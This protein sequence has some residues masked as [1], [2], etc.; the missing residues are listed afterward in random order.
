MKLTAKLLCLCLALCVALSF[1]ACNK[2]N[3]TLQP[4][5]ELPNDSDSALIYFLSGAKYGEKVYSLDQLDIYSQDSCY[6][7]FDANGM[8]ELVINDFCY[9]EFTYE[10]GIIT[11]TL[12]GA[13]SDYTILGDSLS[14][15]Q[16]GV[17][18]VFTRGEIPESM[19]PQEDETQEI[20][21][22][23]IPEE[24]IAPEG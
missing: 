4:T 22:D 10:N 2:E 24:E 15:V 7:F 23:A 9:I 1:G 14:L 12:S 20:V 8:G 3:G 17:T 21:E 16:D 5:K 19:L 13:T 18:L 6:I 11:D